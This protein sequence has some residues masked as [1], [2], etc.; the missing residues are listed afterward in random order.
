MGRPGDNQSRWQSV[1][2]MGRPSDGGGGGLRGSL[3]SERNLLYESRGN[4]VCGFALGR[5]SFRKAKCLSHSETRIH[6]DKMNN[7]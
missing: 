6:S 7:F 5:I 4:K 2:V 3:G 1:P